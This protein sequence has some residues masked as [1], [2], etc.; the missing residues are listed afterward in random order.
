[1]AYSEIMQK[2]YNKTVETLE[3]IN[4][5][6]NLIFDENHKKDVEVK[7][8]NLKFEALEH[9]VYNERAINTKLK[10]RLNEAEIDFETL[11]R[12]VTT[13]SEMDSIQV[14]ALEAKCIGMYKQYISEQRQKKQWSDSY[15]REYTQHLAVGVELKKMEGSFQEEVSRNHDL[16]KDIDNLKKANNEVQRLLD[17]VTDEKVDFM[18]KLERKNREIESAKLVLNNFEAHNEAYIKKL[19][20]HGNALSEKLARMHDSK[21]ME[22]EDYTARCLMNVEKVG[23]K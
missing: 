17:S 14:E 1:M 7:A 13:N 12:R 9:V 11:S 5:Q 15:Q 20:D 19:K 10:D 6:R 18:A 2:D 22:I 16:K 23:I 21:Q 4:K 8:A 3:V